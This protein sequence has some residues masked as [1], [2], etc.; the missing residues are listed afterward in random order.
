MKVLIADDSSVSRRLLEATLVR[1]E[2]EVQVACDGSEALTLLRQPDAPTLAI[3]DWMM[4]SLTGPE[5][6]QLVRHEAREPYIYIILLTSRGQRED[7][8]EGLESGADDYLVKPFD[9]HEL[10]LR[11]RAGRRILDLQ[12][13]LM[14]AREAL[15]IQATRDPRA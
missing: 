2:Y 3:L 7:L 8:L 12:A 5:V 15:R 1:W 6:C 4:P 10:K 14:R 11:L 9:Q 13:E